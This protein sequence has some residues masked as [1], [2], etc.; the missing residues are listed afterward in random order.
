MTTSRS[1]NLHVF[2]T[3]A[4]LSEQIATYVAKLSAQAVASQ[5]RFMVA[6]SGGSMPKILAANLITEPLRQQIDWSKW[7][8]FW[9]D[10][11]CVPLEHADSSYR[12]AREHF[13]E[14]VSIPSVQIYAFDPSLEPEAAAIA[15]Q[16]TMA[17]VFQPALGQLP[18]FDLILLGMGEDGHTASLFPNHP[19]LNENKRWVAPIFDS[20]KPPSERIT[21]TLAVINNA[22]N[23][24]VIATGRG[25]ADILPKVL[26]P[27]PDSK[28]LPARMVQPVHGDLH[29][30]VDKAA[31]AGL[32]LPKA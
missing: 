2:D 1:T 24:A 30:F 11:R 12:L 21:L 22:E 5:G 18:R 8:V 17:Q 13:F 3:V 7:H 28:P 10:E 29:W 19:L 31:A 25:K 27:P 26:D 20:P 23:V 9:A 14:Q 16:A 15:Y 32:K 6:I 4:A